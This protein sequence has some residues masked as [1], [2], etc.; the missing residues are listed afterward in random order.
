MPAFLKTVESA[1]RLL[2]LMLDQICDPQ[3]FGALLRSAECFGVNGVVW[4]KNRGTDL[5]PVAAKASCGASELLP[6][7][8]IANLAEALTQFQ[9]E[10]F[11]AVASTLS[12]GAERVDQI[13]FA[14]KTLLVLG[15]EG[16]GIQPLIQK[17]CDRS[18]YIPMAGKIESLNV[19]QAAAVLLYCA[20]KN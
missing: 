20:S 19:A 2:V 17:R 14:P 6:L 12:P 7:I 16:E 15:S 8:R 1:D 5:T 18:I 13:Q 3:N 10:G 4:S 9:K 11:E